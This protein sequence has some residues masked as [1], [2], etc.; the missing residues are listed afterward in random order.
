MTDTPLSPSM[1]MAQRNHRV[2]L[3]PLFDRLAAG[4]LD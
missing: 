4:W 3:L 2:A 1:L